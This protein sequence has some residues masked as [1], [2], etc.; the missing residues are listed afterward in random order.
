MRSNFVSLI[1][2]F[3]AAVVAAAQTVVIIGTGTSTNTAYSYPAPYGNWYGG[4]RHQI[5]VRASEIQ[6]AGGSAGYITSLGFN[7]SATNGI[8][9]LQNFTIKLKHTTAT[10]V[11]GWDLSGWTTVYTVSSYTVTTG[12]NVHTFATPFAWDGTSNLLIEVCFNNLSYT[13]NASTYYTT[14]SYT[15]VIYYRSD[16]DNTV[17]GDMSGCDWCTYTSSNRPNIRLTIQAGAPNDAGITAIT[18]PAVPFAAGTQSIAVQLKNYGTNTLTSVT[19]NWS[20]NGTLQTAYNWTGSL[21]SGATT[22]VT[23]GNYTFAPRTLYTF[24]VWT[25]N[26][27]GA[28]DGNTANDTLTTQLGAALAGAYTIGGSTPDFTTVVQAVDYLHRAGVL[29]TVLFRIR[30]GTYSGQL[31]FGA[32]PGAGSANRRITFEAESGDAT[33]VVIQG[34]NTSAANYVVAL[35]GTDWLTFRN[36]TFTSNGT[37]PYYRVVYLTGGTENITFDGCVLNGGPA[38][39]WYGQ[40]DVVFYS[41]GNACHNLTVR[42]T[43]FNGGSVALWLEYYAGPLQGIQISGNTFQDFYWAGALITSAQAA[44]IDNN[45]LRALSGSGWNYGLYLYNLPGSFRVERNVIS[46]DG[47]YGLYLDWRSSAEPTALVV[48]NAVQV[49]SGTANFAAGIYIYSANVNIYHNTVY[50]G[51]SDASSVAFYAD[52]YQGVRVVNNIFVNA[53]GGYAYQGSSW[54]GIITSDYNNLYTSGSYIGQWGWT[55]YTDLAAWRAA[56]GL[57]GNSVSVLP[58]FAADRYHLTQVEENLYGTTALLAVVSEDIDGEQR[59]NPYMGSDEVIPVITIVQQPQDTVYGC[60][61]SDVTFSVQA[62]ITFNGTLSYQ[63]LRN[64]A[65]IP[66]GYDG[67]FFGTT[68]PVLRISNTQGQDA[69]S[70]ACLITG[71]SGADPVLSDLSELIIAVPLTIVEHPTSVLTCVEGEAVLQVIAD[72]TVLGYQWQKMTPQGWQDITGATSAIYRVTNAD[73]SQSGA[74][75]CLV[76]GTC[77][78]DTVPTEV[79]IIYVAGPT[80]IVSSPDTVVVALGGRAEMEVEANVVG[81]P[82]TYQAEYQWYRGGV[83]LVDGGR[84]SGARSSRLV[85]EPVEAGDVGG[86]YWVEVRG[87]CG[88]AEQR[89]YAIVAPEVRIVRQ[90]GGGRFC[91]GSAVELSVEVELGGGAQGVEYRWRRNGQPLVDGGNVSGA[92]SARLRIEPI[93]VGD[94]GRYDVVLRVYPGGGEVVSQGAE[95]VVVEPVQVVRQPVGGRWC[96]GQTM[97]LEVEAQGGEQY[98]WYRDGQPIAGA[99]GRRYEKV[100]EAGDGGRYWCVVSNVCG[101][102]QTAEV[103]V[104]VVRLPRLVRDVPAVVQVGVGQTLVLEVEASG[105]GIGYQW[106]RDGQPIAGAV[107]RRYEKV[108]EAGDAGVYWCVIGNECD[109]IESGRVRVDVVVG[110]AEVEGM[111]GVQV[112]PQPVVGGMMEVWYGV[113]AEGRVVV[114]DVTGR[115]VGSW[116]VRG[117]GR[118]GVVVEGSGVYVVQL[119]E[120]GRIRGQQMVLVVR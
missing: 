116:S 78:T 101:E 8:A 75:R 72:G 63:W 59:R 109:T 12:W 81:A 60:Q 99:V 105:D 29:D 42:G 17:C 51:S 113:E 95:V 53:G 80:Q 120:G 112:R 74:Y 34:S 114:R 73:Y 32:I 33:T 50:I 31:A 91:V 56:T 15:S 89:G 70:Y 24:R 37:S 87:V 69:G 90:P 84:I 4:A 64:G 40:E 117:R 85:I 27:N 23:I 68:T 107:G 38:I 18:A 62:T 5:L 67:R 13:Y 1:G 86:D 65:P 26:P 16:Y 36:L 77:G 25:A 98:Q 57:E 79:A 102:E 76:F 54:S 47:G 94:G 20:V 118:L 108:A 96:E 19:I 43:T 14:T 58:P 103:V 111:R 48:N 97:V 10:D 21:A 3:V 6:A 22:T 49:G 52:G 11:T 100:A 88:V 30:N 104:E 115:E 106:Y 39:Y 44:R 55:D 83:A 41:S 46:L 82:P 45:V 2:L 61:G 92:S 28:S 71:N 93:G 35:N 119:E 110:V 66:E 7:V 9:A